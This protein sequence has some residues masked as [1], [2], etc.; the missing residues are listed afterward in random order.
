MTTNQA[1]ASI[2][3]YSYSGGVVG[4]RH[5]DRWGYP[6]RRNDPNGDSAGLLGADDHAE[7]PGR[8]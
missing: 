5:C 7:I 1:N 2:E 3:V 6:Q 8:P 4:P